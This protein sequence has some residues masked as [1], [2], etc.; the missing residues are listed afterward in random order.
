V[1]GSGEQELRGFMTVCC[2]GNYREVASELLDCLLESRL[3]DKTRSIEISLLG[4]P[5]DQRVIERLI[6]PLEKITIGHRSC[7]LE[8]YEFPALGLLQDVCRTWSGLVFY[9]HTKGVSHEPENQHL[10]YWR[11]LMLDTVVMNHQECVQALRDHDAVGTNWRGNHYSGNFWW[12]RAEHVRSLPDVRAMRHSPQFITTDPV[13]NVRLQCEFWLSMSW[14]RFK[15]LGVEG[16]DLYRTIRWSTTAADIINELLQAHDGD[17]YLELVV[18][19]PS[20]YFTQVGAS[21]KHVVSSHADPAS[22]MTEDAFLASNEGDGSYDVIFLDDWHDEAH[23]LRVLNGCLRKV[24]QYGAIVVHDTNPPT[25]WHQRPAAE[26]APDTEWNGDVWKAVARFRAIHPEIDVRTVDTDWGCTVIRPSVRASQ[27]VPIDAAAALTWET[28]QRRRA[29]LLNI[30]P[31][32]R[33]RRD[34]YCASFM[35]GSSRIVHRTDVINCLISLLGLERY[36]EVGVGQGETFDQVAAPLRQSV[37]PSGRP[38][39]RMTSDEFFSQDLGC[40]QYDLIFIDALHEEDQCLRDIEH[41]VQRLSP[42]GCV[43]V[44]DTNPPTE[45]HQ[46][47][48]AEYEPGTEWNGDVWKAIVRF[49]QRHPDFAAVTLDVDWGCTVLRASAIPQPWLPPAIELKWS[50]LCEHRAEL[51]NLRPP[52]WA[53]VLRFLDLTPSAAENGSTR[54]T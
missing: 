18:D 20:I 12:A 31:V 10:R 16:L 14:G 22:S 6:R 2:L 53:E 23:C 37:D 11:M 47:P 38:T 30:V 29:E 21:V 1:N 42:N 34:L 52:D 9:L 49:R 27:S 4:P 17:R 41:A 36:L 5:D 3:Y 44:H 26:Y 33:F 19:G 54:G 24:S 32:R 40:M 50:T 13:G 28:F 8:E 35:L 51:L 7:D 43:V 45:W 15:N 48:A 25:A 39:W 46:R